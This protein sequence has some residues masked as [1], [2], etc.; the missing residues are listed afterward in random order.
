VIRSKDAPTPAAVR[1]SLNK[2]GGAALIAT[3]NL[4]AKPAGTSAQSA[5]NL[6]RHL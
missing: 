5:R 6:K 1:R 3:H 4:R 2:T